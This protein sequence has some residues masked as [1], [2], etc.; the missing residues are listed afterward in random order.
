MAHSEELVAS[1]LERI[2]GHEGGF[3]QDPDDPGNWTG[4]KVGLG[5]CV[6]TKWGIAANT[7]GEGPTLPRGRVPIRQLTSSEAAYVYRRDYLDHIYAEQFED[8]VAFQLL[9]FAINS[10]PRRAVMALQR[11]VGVKPDGSWGPVSAKA[12]AQH[13]E[14]DLVK[15]LVAE[16]LEFMASL[17]NW[18]SAGRGWARRLARNLRYGALDS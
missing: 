2:I 4:G 1:W 9:D 7:Y 14:S 5:D 17:P 15:L 16:R 18:E 10:G 12:L 8:G 13:S 6:G 3:T 11:A